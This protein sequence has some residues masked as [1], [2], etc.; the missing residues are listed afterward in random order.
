MKYSVH[1]WIV[2]HPNFIQYLISDEWLKVTVIGSKYKQ[3]VPEFLLQIS[4]WE[5]QNVMVILYYKGGLEKVHNKNE[6]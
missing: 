2:Y 5:L 6:K 4:M 1:N 3:D